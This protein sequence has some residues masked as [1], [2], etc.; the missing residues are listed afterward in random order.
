MSEPQKGKRRIDQKPKK[1]HR[2][3]RKSAV[4]NPV[5]LPKKYLNN[6]WF[7]PFIINWGQKAGSHF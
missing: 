3:A 5:S 6:I 1:E 7:F 2:K 4:G